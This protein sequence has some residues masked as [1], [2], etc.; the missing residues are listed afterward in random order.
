MLQVSVNCWSSGVNARGSRLIIVVVELGAVKIYV[1]DVQ[2][3]R[4]KERQDETQ[5]I[6][7]IDGFLCFIPRWMLTY[8]FAGFLKISPCVWPNSG[9]V[10]VLCFRTLRATLL[11]QRTYKFALEVIQKKIAQFLVLLTLP[12]E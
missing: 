10:L 7:K 11:S 9:L 3:L 4:K 5:F 6:T 12:A 2:A 1:T 8:L